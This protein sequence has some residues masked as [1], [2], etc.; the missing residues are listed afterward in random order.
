MT[1]T[2]VRRTRSRATWRAPAA[3][4][5][6]GTRRAGRHVHPRRVCGDTGPTAI[7]C[8]VD[9]D[10]RGGYLGGGGRLGHRRRRRMFDFTIPQG[11]TADT[12]GHG[13][14]I[15]GRLTAKGDL[16]VRGA[17]AGVRVGCG[18]GC[19]TTGKPCTRTPLPARVGEY[20]RWRNELAGC[21]HPPQTLTTA[22]WRCGTGRRGRWWT[23]TAGWRE[24]SAS[25]TNATLDS[26]GSLQMRRVGNA[27]T[28]RVLLGILPSWQ[29]VG[30]S[31]MPRPSV[32]DQQSDAYRAGG[33][34]ATMP[35]SSM[36]SVLWIGG[37]SM[38]PSFR[39]RP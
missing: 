11:A 33:D 21:Y 30:E 1:W 32:S 19:G 39:P 23:T 8:R 10:G 18:A 13:P 9:Y 2:G 24:V 6:R 31:S 16:A 38:S 36:T 27:V 28:I 29:Q 3:V 20:T 37:V 26:G 14:A 25:V 15:G 17:S 7:G 4:S 12:A 34:C 5:S 35:P 22:S